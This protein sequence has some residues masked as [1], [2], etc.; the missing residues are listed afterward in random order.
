[1]TTTEDEM[2]APVRL[3]FRTVDD[4]WTCFV[5]EGDATDIT[6]NA[7]VLGTIARMP[8]AHEG[9]R[10]QFMEC[11]KAALIVSMEETFEQPV[12]VVR[13]NEMKP[14]ERKD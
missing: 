11:M 4:M 14:N 8:I 5:V 13:W 9:L 10:R 6:P 3:M 7:L 1:M 2:P 12:D